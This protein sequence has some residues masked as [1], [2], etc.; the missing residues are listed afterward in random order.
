MITR[1]WLLLAIP[2]FCA[3]AGAGIAVLQALIV[4]WGEERPFF[5]HIV[6]QCAVGGALGGSL[7]GSALYWWRLR[8]APASTLIDFVAIPLIAG[9]LVA[10]V[11]KAIP[12]AQIAWMSIFATLGALIVLALSS[13]HRQ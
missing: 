2:L 4:F 1:A 9:A 13:T 5:Y 10:A 3:A 7:L 6:L 8:D 11:L 12:G